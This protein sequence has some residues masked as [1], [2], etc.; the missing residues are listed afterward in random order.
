MFWSK[1]LHG[2]HGIKEAYNVKL[3]EM[4]TFI[5]I[6]KHGKKKSIKI[7]PSPIPFFKKYLLLL[8]HKMH[9]VYVCAWMQWHGNE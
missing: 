3:K 9:S 2:K 4:R 6:V 5:H 8:Q 1:F 7:S